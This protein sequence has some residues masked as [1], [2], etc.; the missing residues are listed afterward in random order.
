MR[1]AGHT[2][3]M[4]TGGLNMYSADH[5]PQLLVFAG[6]NGSGKST[7]TKFQ[8]II[9]EYVNADKIKI[10]TG[11]TDLEAA[12]QAEKMREFLLAHRM[13]FTFETVLSTPRNLLLIRR[14]HEAGYYIRVIFVLTTDS[15]INVLRVAERVRKGGHDV[16]V[17]KIHSRY[18]KSLENIRELYKYT[19]DL[20]IYDN[21]GEAPVLICTVHDSILQYYP[22]EHWTDKEV[23][24]LFYRE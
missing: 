17:E 11:C 2:E 9:G 16:P 18:Q 7:V 12:Q 20:W 5:R 19:D 4:M 23:L 6:P 8:R 15:S 10:A 3:N 14:A 13:D 24:G 21:S 1:Q 22:N